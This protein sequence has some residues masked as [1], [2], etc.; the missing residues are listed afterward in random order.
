MVRCDTI[1]DRWNALPKEH[2]VNYIALLGEPDD[3]LHTR[4]LNQLDFQAVAF[5]LNVWHVKPKGHPWEKSIEIECYVCLAALA[6]AIR[7]G[8]S[9]NILH[10]LVD[11]FQV[12][13]ENALLAD[14]RDLQ[15]IVTLRR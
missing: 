3:R 7:K 1:E 8:S 6:F 5:I 9:M 14:V 15:R 4:E 13:C 2:D 10:S 11:H 12:E